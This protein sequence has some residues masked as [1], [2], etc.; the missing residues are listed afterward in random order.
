MVVVFFRVADERA[1][2]PARAFAAA[3]GQALVGERRRVA[4]DPGEPAVPGHMRIVRL[5]DV[6]RQPGLCPANFYETRFVLKVGAPGRRPSW[7]ASA[8]RRTL[9][10]VWLSR[11]MRAVT[12][13]D[14]SLS[15]RL[16]DGAPQL[17]GLSLRGSQA[18]PPPIVVV[19]VAALPAAVDDTVVDHVPD[20]RIQLVG[21]P[22]AFEQGVDGRVVGPGHDQRNAAQVVLAL[23]ARHADPGFERFAAAMPGGFEHRPGDA[24]VATAQRQP[25][26]E[27]RRAKGIAGE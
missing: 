3:V 2:F 20:V 19:G 10:A 26:V 18:R 16:M 5:L 24:L 8:S 9:A 11:P 27:D 15:D 23:D 4:P 22:A 17:V 1:R 13:V 12:R 6:E 21:A 7:R 14:S 25:V